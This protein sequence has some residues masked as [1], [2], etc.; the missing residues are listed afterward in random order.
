M[1]RLPFC[2]HVPSCVAC[3]HKQ[4]LIPS[5]LRPLAFPST[6][7]PF[8]YQAPLWFALDSSALPPT[9]LVV[10]ALDAKY[11]EESS[12]MLQHLNASDERGATRQR[13]G[14]HERVVVPGCGHAV[15]IEEPLALLA[16]LLAHHALHLV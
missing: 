3:P 1:F 7:N 14:H 12:R 11:V 6:L 4:D 2:G 9:T 8:P 5:A 16:A 15:H 13:G 10:G